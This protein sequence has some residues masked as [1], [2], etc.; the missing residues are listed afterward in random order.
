MLAEDV[1]CRVISVFPPFLPHHQSK[2]TQDSGSVTLVSKHILVR[3]TCV[4]R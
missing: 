3:K 2:A 1:T 4:R